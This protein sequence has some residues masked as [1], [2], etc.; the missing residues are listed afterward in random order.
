MRK[1]HCAHANVY[2]S[3]VFHFLASMR[4]ASSTVHMTIVV[5]YNVVRVL[6]HPQIPAACEGPPCVWNCCLLRE[7]PQ[8][9]YCYAFFNHAAATEKV[10]PLNAELYPIFHLLALLA[11]HHILHVSRIRVN[12]LAIPKSNIC[13]FISADPCAVREQLCIWISSPRLQSTMLCGYF[14]TAS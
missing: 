11:A 4:C 7:V 13:A 12:L 6:L 5:Q 9:L 2:Y 8:P 14:G 10:N 1:L 3:I